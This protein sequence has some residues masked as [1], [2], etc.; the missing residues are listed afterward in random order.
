LAYKIDQHEK[1]PNQ[2]S[3]AAKVAAY[4]QGN[5]NTDYRAIM[6]RECG[7]RVKLIHLGVS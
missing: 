7:Q 2:P 1:N 3:T 5:E 6:I 4:F